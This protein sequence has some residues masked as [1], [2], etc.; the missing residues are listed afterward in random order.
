MARHTGV[1]LNAPP[2][3]YFYNSLNV[4]QMDIANAQQR[5]FAVPTGQARMQA[6]EN[7]NR[8][9][10]LADQPLTAST[11]VYCDFG[12]PPSKAAIFCFGLDW[13]IDAPGL[14][15]WRGG[16]AGS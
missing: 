12:N 9:S 10:M 15:S 14:L 2:A 13:E 7:D 1:S 11:M 8:G 16:T 6:G 3:P 5:P 4:H